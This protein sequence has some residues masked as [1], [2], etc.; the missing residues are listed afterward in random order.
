MKLLICI[1]S[2]TDPLYLQRQ[3][4]C[5][6]T[7]LKDSPV[8]Y[9]FFRDAELGLDETDPLIRQLRMKRICQYA[10]AN[11]Y[12]FIF[13]TDSDAYVW[14]NRLL[15]C[16]YESQ[17]YMGYCLNYP[18]HLGGNRTAHGGTGFFLSR[19]AMQI[20]VDGEHFPAGNGT[21]W[22]DIWTGELLKKHGI[23]CYRD[24]RFLDGYGNEDISPDML[25]A[26]HQ[27]I[28][29]HPVSE[30]SQRAFFTLGPVSDEA[31]PPALPIFEPERTYNYGTRDRNCPCE[32]CR[33]L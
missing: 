27:Y 15:L 30:D 2:K 5:E 1:P 25:P 6:A 32:Y 11:G 12:D 8:P 21:Y 14:V 13:R 7:W 26:N 22:A 24:T 18:E 23:R 33:G 17:D 10:L 4:V 20:V 3:A 19:R 29:I 31:T 9:R 16:G 28:A